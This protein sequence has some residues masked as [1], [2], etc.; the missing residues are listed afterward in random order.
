[1][2]RI[3]LPVY[4]NPI[5]IQSRGRSGLPVSSSPIH[6]QPKG[7]S[8][9]PVSSSPIFITTGEIVQLGLKLKLIGQM[10]DGSQAP[11]SILNNAIWTVVNPSIAKIEGD[12]LIAL[13]KGTTLVRAE[14]NGIRAEAT[15]IVGDVLRAPTIDT[16]QLSPKNLNIKVGSMITINT[17]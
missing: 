8:G 1:M 9:L 7:R 16:L 10:R 2:S 4:S 6:I 13:A 5:E 3:G 11:L 15:I 14:I 17:L 12:E